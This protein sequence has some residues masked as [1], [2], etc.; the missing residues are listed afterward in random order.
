MPNE[1]MIAT[2]GESQLLLPGLVAAGLAANDCVKYL[3]TLV[4]A[5]R[6]AADGV[7]DQGTLRDERVACGVEDS[8]LDA[9][10]A[11]SIREP[12]GRYRIPGADRL[13]QW[14]VDEVQCHGRNPDGRGDS[15]PHLE[16]CVRVG[17]RRQA[18]GHLATRERH[19][20][21]VARL[22]T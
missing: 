8:R 19:D 7:G 5:A 4:Q 15:G 3:L 9:V 1:R 12:D 22:R 16:G 17:V 11:E 20:D 2:L 6:A 18:R 21:V 13:S 14:A 10:V